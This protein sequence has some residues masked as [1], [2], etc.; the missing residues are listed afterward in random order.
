MKDF[1]KRKRN[2]R[3][4]ASAL[5][6]VMAGFLVWG[7]FPWQAAA[8]GTT[9]ADDVT[10]NK[11]HDP[12]ALDD[13]T[14]NV[15]RIW[16]DKSV[17]TGNVKLTSNT[18]ASA[19]IKKK[20]GS[21]FLVGLSALSSTAKI[22]GQTT[23]PL[24]IVLVLDVS[25]S[26]DDESGGYQE[27]YQLDPSNT[28]Y[29]LRS[30]EYTKVRYSDFLGSWY[31]WGFGMTSVTPKTSADDT[32]SSH[33][34]FY[35]YTSVKKMTTLKNAVNSFI[36]RSAD[37]NDK[38]PDNLKSRISLVK[39]AGKKKK[40]KDDKDVVG[41]DTYRDGRYTYNYTQIVSEYEAYNKDNKNDLK[42]KVNALNPGGATRADYAMDH[43]K[44]LVG[45]SK[46][47]EQNNP[48][49]KNVKRIV[50]FFT[51]G[52]PTSG[53]QFEDGVANAAIT[54]AKGIK[55]DLDADIY[56]IGVFDSAN[57]S[58]TK[59]SFNA[60]M[61]GMSSNYPDAETYKK[62]GT[63][64]KDS[65]GNDTQFYKAATDASELNNIFNE[66][67]EDIVADAQSPTHVEGEDP[68][69]SG[70]ITFTDQLGDYM[71]VDDMNALV[72]ANQMLTSETK[73]YSSTE[74]TAGN[75]TTVKYTF[76]YV[77]PD[78]NHV[79]PEGNLKNIVITVEKATG[80]DQ[81]HVGD[82]VT[83]K[84]PASLIPLRYY[85][86]DK[87]G[88]MTIDETYPMRLFYDVSLKDGVAEKIEN[89]DELLRAYID[90][91][92]DDEGH[93]HFYSNKYDKKS[94]NTDSA[95][96]GAYA[97]FVPATTNDFYYFQEDT[98][99]Y[100]NE[101]CTSPATGELDKSGD[102]IYYY[103][104]TITSWEKAVKQKRRKIQ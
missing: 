86:I 11:W 89:P 55:L 18:R 70:Y 95:G 101:A 35:E 6:V 48:N 34:Q 54:T 32:D 26:M 25:G 76:D 41:N 69:Q 7:L 49:R 59:G 44:T 96:I 99:L 17:S 75:K 8:A 100:T 71:Q 79:Y 77:I 38:L 16:T 92:K 78:T 94:Q 39:F 64:A 5:A 10:I 102:T 57:A 13:S 72:Y 63:R 91:N 19:D 14:K 9:V 43:A 22:M 103:S 24:D 87:D 67:T 82:L 37:E 51:D 56:T 23:V 97:H 74:T 93:V 58:D 40:D 42:N 50:I 53:N 45:S 4:A 65:K 33:D 28:Y 36:D 12:E 15:G 52:E 104:V 83:V 66:I 85:Q 84:I 29:I 68:H 73:G 21:D 20:D 62:L 30:G 60:Y 1:W 88:K 61:H 80:D 27:V 46:T 31:Y 90:A 3:I 81:L 98:F 47:D 2:K